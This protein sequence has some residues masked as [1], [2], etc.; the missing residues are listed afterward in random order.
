MLP[1]KRRYSN[2]RSVR[3]FLFWQRGSVSD[4]PL[5]FSC[6]SWTCQNATNYSVED[7]AW[8]WRLPE[9][10]APR[11]HLVEIFGVLYI[12]GITVYDREPVKGFIFVGCN[13][14]N[15][16]F[17]IAYAPRPIKPVLVLGRCEGEH[18]AL[19]IVETDNNAKMGLGGGQRP[20]RHEEHI[21]LRQHSSHTLLNA[22]A[23]K[24]G[25]FQEHF[26]VERNGGLI[27]L[28]IL[29]GL[30]PTGQKEVCVVHPDS[31][32]A[33]LYARL[34]RLPFGEMVCIFHE[35]VMERPLGQ[36][37]VKGFNL[38]LAQLVVVRLLRTFN[39]KYRLSAFSCPPGIFHNDV[40]RSGLV[41]IHFFNEFFR[42]GC[43]RSIL[44][45]VIRIPNDRRC[46][47]AQMVSVG[48]ID[49]FECVE[50]GETH[51]FDIIGK[52]TQHL[53]DSLLLVCHG[54]NY[55]KTCE[56]MSNRRHTHP[57]RTFSGVIYPSFQKS[58]IKPYENL[59]SDP[60][61]FIFISC[62]PSR[63]QSRSRFGSL[64]SD[65]GKNGN[66]PI[67]TRRFFA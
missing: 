21:P 57:Y 17:G 24:C 32:R 66:D 6:G 7:F 2:A 40:F 64:H 58:P 1:W 20:V 16:L 38:G 27:H 50:F 33:I 67:L 46:V 51:A 63:P 14:N 59:F 29:V 5:D 11:H 18:N 56:S 53:Y 23:P 26:P 52:I 12:D 25:I 3:G 41:P 65:G 61:F 4:K 30:P 45:G 42:L 9:H 28:A 35:I 47:F 62:T 60:F 39:M 44:H 22:K 34:R 8:H 37:H 31:S 54:A 19:A 43:D 15:C 48:K 55:T 49:K 36:C 13:L 10:I